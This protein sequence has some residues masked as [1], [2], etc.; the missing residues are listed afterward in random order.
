MCDTLTW[1][2]VWRFIQKILDKHLIISLYS[3]YIKYN[4]QKLAMND[5]CG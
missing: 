2:L 1:D 4:I 5:F 3:N